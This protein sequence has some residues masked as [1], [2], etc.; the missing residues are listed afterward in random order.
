VTSRASKRKKP[1]QKPTADQC[2]LCEGA[3]HP[4]ELPPDATARP[5]WGTLATA[6]MQ[7]CMWHITSGV[8]A[9]H[10][11]NGVTEEEAVAAV[12]DPTVGVARA[13]TFLAAGMFAAGEAHASAAAMEY[14]G[15]HVMDE[16]F[17]ALVELGGPGRYVV[18]LGPQGRAI[19]SPRR[20]H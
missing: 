5:G 16:F 10:R 3:H 4:L 18:E 8:F 15:D 1:T 9:L 17:R 6:V 20:V 13:A 14:A 2:L 11:A 12:L 19:G 7:D